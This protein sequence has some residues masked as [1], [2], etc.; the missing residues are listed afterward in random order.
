MAST[1]HLVQPASHP[2]AHKISANEKEF[3]YNQI[4]IG[5][6]GEQIIC[7]VLQEKSKFPV[8]HLFFFPILELGR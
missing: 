4:N 1:E 2:H 7:Y 8:F 6:L 5:K 3:R